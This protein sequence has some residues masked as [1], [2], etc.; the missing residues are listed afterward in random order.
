MQQGEE[1][2][3]IRVVMFWCWPARGRIEDFTGWVSK[4]LVF[5]SLLAGERAKLFFG[6]EAGMFSII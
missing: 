3:G 2:M 4:V 6:R 5:S 1:F